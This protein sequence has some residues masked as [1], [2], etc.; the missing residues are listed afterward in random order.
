[1]KL[2]MMND[3]ACYSN[4]CITKVMGGLLQS[5]TSQT[6]FKM[7]V[8]LLF[9]SILLC[10]FLCNRKCLRWFGTEIERLQNTKGRTFIDVYWLV[11]ELVYWP[12]Q[13]LGYYVSLMWFGIF[14]DYNSC[15]SCNFIIFCACSLGCYLR[16]KK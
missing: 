15:A 14:T 6:P 1:M 8:C 4:P 9:C 2:F 3:F 16:G 13:I 12:C 11:K 5:K 10:T 7:H